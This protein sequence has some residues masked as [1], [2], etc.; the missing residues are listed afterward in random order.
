MGGGSLGVG[1]VGQ[2]DGAQDRI[3]NRHDSRGRSSGKSQ[4]RRN[5]RVSWRHQVHPRP[6]LCSNSN[7]IS[8]PLLGMV[9]NGSN[10]TPREEDMWSLC[11]G[12]KS[13]VCPP[14]HRSPQPRLRLLRQPVHSNQHHHCTKRQYQYQHQHQHQQHE[15]K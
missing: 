9:Q 12:T 4:Q 7:Y 5:R 14:L 6:P 8:A 2:G 15:Q 10:Y 1:G 3:K 13:S 11:L